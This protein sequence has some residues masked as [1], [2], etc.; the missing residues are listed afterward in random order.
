M[1]VHRSPL[2]INV[3]RGY[4]RSDFAKRRS[5]W[6][7]ITR[8]W[9]AKSTFSF[10]GTMISSAPLE[11]KIAARR[12]NGAGNEWRKYRRRTRITRFPVRERRLMEWFR[13]G[14]GDGIS[15]NAIEKDRRCLQFELLP[16]VFVTKKNCRWKR[17]ILDW[18]KE[19]SEFQKKKGAP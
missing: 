1:S 3:S 6:P 11:K 7:T 10:P 18:K 17:K 5:I 15:I 12:N 8:P 2:R 4:R 16:Q 13:A 9:S 14:F 19:F